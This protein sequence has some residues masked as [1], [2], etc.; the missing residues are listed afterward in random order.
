MLIVDVTPVD[1]RPSGVGLYV[2]HLVRELWGLGCGVRGVYQPGMRGWL[3]GRRELPGV[4]REFNDRIHHFP[5]PVRISNLLL[6]CWPQFFATYLE[7]K[8]GYPEIFHGTNYTVFPFKQSRQVLTL[9]DVTFARYPQ[10]VNQVVQQYE[11]RVRQCLGWTDLVITISDSSKRDIVRYLGV[12]PDRVWVTPL[13]SRYTSADVQ[14]LIRNTD[15]PA[16]FNHP[17]PYLLF[18]STIE[19]RKNVIS[20][21]RAFNYL[22]EH[23]HIPHQLVLI[24]RKGWLYE[25]IFEAIERSPY[26]EDIHHL[27]YVSDQLVAQYYHHA[28]AVVYP[29]HYEGFGLPVLEAMMF[30]APVITSNTSSLP[31]VAGDAAVMI[32]PDDPLELAEGIFNVIDDRTFRQDLIQRGRVQAAQFSW[33]QTAQET[34]KAYQSLL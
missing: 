1:G 13:A 3:R 16:P 26:R 11:R 20:L 17:T 34:L 23:H 22:K 18:V 15:L 2:C 5:C 21:I 9:Y 14:T 32:N 28:D 4:L 24:G 33:R 27:N 6:D 25:P 31:E 29:S 12:D 30:G 8:L 10:Y 19:P 7:P